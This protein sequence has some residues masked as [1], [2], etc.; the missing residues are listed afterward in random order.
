MGHLA[1][2]F[3]PHRVG[4]VRR[5]ARSSEEG[6]GDRQVCKRAL[7]LKGAKRYVVGEGGTRTGHCRCSRRSVNSAFSGGRQRSIEILKS[8]RSLSR[9]R[10]S[11]RRG[12]HTATTAVAPAATLGSNVG[13]HNAGGPR[14]AWRSGISCAA[15]NRIDG[16]H[17]RH[18][19]VDSALAK[20]PMLKKLAVDG[21]RR[22]QIVHAKG[23]RKE[24]CG[25]TSSM[26]ASRTISMQS[27]RKTPRTGLRANQR[28]SKRAGAAV[29]A[30]P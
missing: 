23:A 25:R 24:R 17:Y 18:S 27:S 26:S 15:P 5:D 2:R 6:I 12:S 8:G 4:A 11:R 1:R 19:T 3:E 29:C 7:K 22:G 10:C 14:L 13:W 21:G 20:I 16:G 9:C 28:Y 30:R